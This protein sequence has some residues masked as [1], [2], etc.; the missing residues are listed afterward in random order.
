M[1][2]SGFAWA[3]L[4]YTKDIHGELAQL[5]SLEDT[6]STRQTVQALLIARSAA[7]REA[8]KGSMALKSL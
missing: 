5:G 8:L 7:G 1:F 6:S 3:T 2:G 4:K